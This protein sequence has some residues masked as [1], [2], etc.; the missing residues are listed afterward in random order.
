MK[1]IQIIT[2]LTFAGILLALSCEKEKPEPM[3]PYENVFGTWDWVSSTTGWGVTTYV[4]SV[5]YS[6]SLEV[7]PQGAYSWKRNDSIVEALTYTVQIDTVEGAQRFIFR[8]NDSSRVDQ[9]FYIEQ[10]TLN[11]TDQCADC[12][13]H[14]FVRQ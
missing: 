6:Q 14:K 1:N 11:L 9:S 8:F 7:T 2:M 5:D 4:D 3:L 13:A 10:D 12:D